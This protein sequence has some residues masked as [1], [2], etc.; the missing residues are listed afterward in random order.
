ME[1]QLWSPMAM[2]RVL[3]ITPGVKGGSMAFRQVL[4]NDTNMKS[5]LLL[6]LFALYYCTRHCRK[7]KHPLYK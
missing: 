2:M 5:D 1:K 7:A 6:H 4:D 3:V